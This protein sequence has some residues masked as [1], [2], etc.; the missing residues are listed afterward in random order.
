MSGNGAGTTLAEAL[1]E[2]AVRVDPEAL[3]R[4]R[5]DRVADSIA[6]TVAMVVAGGARAEMAPL[7][8]HAVGVGLGAEQA[9]VWG[10]G[11]R[12]S[13][14]VAAMLNATAGHLLDFD[15][16]HYLIHG[17]PSTVVVP[18]A[19]AAAQS[20]NAGGNRVHAGVIAGLGVMAVMARA[21]GPEHYSDGWHSTSTCGVFGAAAAAAVALDL[22]ADRTANA[23]AI[24]ASS[25]QGVRANFGT[26]LKPF[27]A[28][29]AAR[30][31]VEAAMLS[32]AGVDA[33]PNAL[34]SGLGA[35][36]LYGRRDD[37]AGV[38]ARLIAAGLVDA[39][40]A[41]DDLGLKLYPC[42]RGAHFAIDAA[43]DAR[44]LVPAGVTIVGARVVVPLGSRTALIY[45][46]PA[47]GLEAKFSLPYTVATAVV[48]GL[49]AI[50]HFE[51]AAVGD[52]AVQQMM[53][54]IEV[55][56]DDS[57]GD[58]SSTMTGRYAEVML[59][60]DDARTFTARVDD[61][62]GSATR[63][64]T[65]DEVDAKFRAAVG[66]VLGDSRAVALLERTRG[67]LHPGASGSALLGV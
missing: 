28:G 38:A 14:P 24:A 41:P 46:D 64:L 33:A 50:A 11:V 49:P 26:L 10:R 6:D 57:H 22:D 39:D 63:P 67:L 59:V 4:D 5:R 43:L 31:G 61:A 56:E 30:A 45:D 53:R 12:A 19:A 15:D 34:E 55:I 54:R 18:A 44:G 29:L 32:A 35:I 2:W 66:P 60:S 42:C 51:D 40:A 52:P 1:A 36:A 47:T 27:H 13:A 48:R 62:R 23:L 37:A 58:L 8:R 9:E 65:R 25:A 21:F 16:T 7:W 20:V 17:H 3:T